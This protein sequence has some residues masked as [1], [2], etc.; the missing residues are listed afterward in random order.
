MLKWSGF[1][2]KLQPLLTNSNRLLWKAF[3]LTSWHLIKESP[4]CS[5]F[6][7][8]KHVPKAGTD[9][10]VNTAVSHAVQN[11]AWAS[12]LNRA[13][14]PMHV[15]APWEDNPTFFDFKWLQNR[16]SWTSSSADLLHQVP[17]WLPAI[18]DT[19][20]SVVGH[21]YHLSGW[22]IYSWWQEIFSKNSSFKYK[23]L[24]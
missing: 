2:Q 22:S 13:A 7:T 15:L 11:R 18:I 23:K 19:L 17:A 4:T 9:H 12:R 8:G 10:H 14:K 5:D 24:F 3:L 16:V 6:S 1:E 21:S 20:L